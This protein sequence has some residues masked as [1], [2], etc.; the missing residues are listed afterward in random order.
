MS[1]VYG[2]CSHGFNSGTSCALSLLRC[3]VNECYGDFSPIEPTSCEVFSSLNVVLVHWRDEM[4]V[5]DFARIFMH[6]VRCSAPVSSLQG[7]CRPKSARAYER[8]GIIRANDS[9]RD[10]DL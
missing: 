10:V 3:R 7:G 9:Q 6:G 1:G 2:P 5:L 8:R 4:R